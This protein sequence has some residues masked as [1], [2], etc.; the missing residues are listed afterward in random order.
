MKKYDTLKTQLN[1]AV[2]GAK[3]D[4]A[5]L[6]TIADEASRISIV[7]R[8][9][10]IIITD[11]DKQFEEKTKLTKVDIGFLFFATALQIARQFLQPK[12]TFRTDD[13]KAAEPFKQKEADKF[14]TLSDEEKEELKK[15]HHQWYNP[16]LKEVMFN[17]VPFDIQFGGGK[18]GFDIFSLPK[19][20]TDLYK[21][22]SPKG[23]RHRT[24][25]LGH[26][27]ILG[28]IFGT[29][30]IATATLTTWKLASYHVKYGPNAGGV[31][32]PKIVNKANTPKMFEHI[33]KKLSNKNIEDKVILATALIREAIHLKSDLYSFASLP[34]PLA[35]LKSPKFAEHLASFGLDM[36]NIGNITTIGEQAM[37]AALVNTIVSMIHGLVNCEDDDNYNFRL[38]E[39]RTRKILKYSNVLASSSNIIY[40]AIK[41]V[42]NMVAAAPLGPG[43]MILG[44][45]PA[46]RDLDLGG[47]LVTLYRIVTDTIFI[48][49]VK[50]EFLEKEFYNR[51]YG[52]EYNF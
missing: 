5:H 38:I 23:M 3:T 34:I 41:A 13:T 44:A 27:P 33:K 47:L 19:E 14:G 20:V 52:E 18:E 2:A 6:N 51:V 32:C 45:A 28:W 48:Q 50:K 4:I 8:D 12:L 49:K 29:A 22:V 16:S 42:P 30:N 17:K 9:A 36:A 24:A 39:T 10:D 1:D 11:I 35:T 46:L 26:D 37:L 15:T 31:I 25:T 43:A 21:S 7:A 40:V